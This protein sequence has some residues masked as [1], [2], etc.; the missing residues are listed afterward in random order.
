MQTKRYFGVASRIILAL[1]L[2]SGCAAESETSQSYEGK[3]SDAPLAEAAFPED[4]GEFAAAS[5]APGASGAAMRQK[6]SRGSA[7]IGDRDLGGIAGG[8][9]QLPEDRL[10]EYTIQVVY[11]T[12]DYRAAR[13]ALLQIAG[14][15]GFV[16]NSYAATD[17]TWSMNTHMRVRV[18]EMYEVLAK[19]D[20]LGELE[21]ER[22]D[23]TDHT[24][25]MVLAERKYKRE[26]LR[27]VRRSRAARNTPAANKNW[28]QREQLIEQSED[29]QDAAEHQ[30]WQVKDRV[31]F[32][33]IQ[34]SLVGPDLPVQVEVPAY[35][36][37]FLILVNWFLELLYALILATPLWLVMLALWLKRGAIKRLLGI[38]SRQQDD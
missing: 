19:L 36:N 18:E 34:V 23:S 33:Q 14:K 22:I 30:Q 10:L 37:A 32:A 5:D 28:A 38:E 17:P 9:L 25:K 3:D 4:A 11:R 16:T 21:S 8:A 35:Q 2:F 1:L 13:H 7:A 31:S 27:L 24:E 12:E 20:A 26:R 15:H 29:R 6:T